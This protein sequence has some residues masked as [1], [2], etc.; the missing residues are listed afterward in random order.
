MQ[1]EGQNALCFGGNYAMIKAT[2][3]KGAA[4]LIKVSAPFSFFR[5]AAPREMVSRMGLGGAE[6]YKKRPTPIVSEILSRYVLSKRADA[7]S[8]NTPD[9]GG[10]SAPLLSI[11]ERMATPITFLT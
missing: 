1:Y 9:G 8:E 3:K 6:N 5:L 11:D 4:N 10:Y 7:K 2:E